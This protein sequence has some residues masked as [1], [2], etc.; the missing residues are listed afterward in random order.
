MTEYHM[1]ALTLTSVRQKGR[2][3]KYQASSTLARTKEPEGRE[4][5]GPDFKL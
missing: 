1:E 4:R 5:W 2:M 3:Q